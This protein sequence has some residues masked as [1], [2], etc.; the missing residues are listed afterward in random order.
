PVAIV[1]R[2]TPNHL[3]TL[4]ALHRLGAG[5]LLLDPAEPPSL[6]RA[7]VAQ[8]GARLAIGTDDPLGCAAAPLPRST[9]GADAPAVAPPGLDTVCF[10]GR[11]SGT[12]RGVP[13]LTPLTHEHERLRGQANGLAMPRTPADRYLALVSMSFA[14]GCRSAQRALMNGGAIILPPPARRAEDVRAA[15]ATHGATWTALTPHHLR[16]LLAGAVPPLP[17]LPG[18]SILVST[19]ALTVAERI[20]VMERLSPDLYMSYGANE[21]GGIVFARPEDLRRHPGTVGRPLPGVEAEVL[22]DRGHPAAPGVVGELRFRHATFPKGYVAPQPGATSRFEDGW[23]HPGDLGLIDP[24]GL[25]FL[26]GRVDDL[27]NVGG[28]K[29]YPADIEECLASHPAVAEAVALGL[30]ASRRG[31]VAAVAV[32]ARAPVTREE[33]LAHCR[34]TIGPQR[35]PDRLQIV[36]EIPKTE[37]GKPDRRALAARFLEADRRRFGGRDH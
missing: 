35:T 2:S 36:Q 31:Q 8:V 4:F 21:V 34:A 6:Q 32:V 11:S 7:L 23:F 17:F 19:A 13:K 1:M 22:D 9:S 30:P 16:Q 5:A 27:I 24:E 37:L 10:F 28:R 29:V 18:V 33:L 20:A 3:A 26:K 15:A 12:T 14:F 25:I